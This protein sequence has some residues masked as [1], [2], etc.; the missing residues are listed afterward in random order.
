MQFANLKW[1]NQQPYS[2]DFDDVY[3]SSD[4]GLAETEYVFIQ[5]NQLSERFAALANTKQSK[6]TFTIIET[7]FGTGLN[8]LC[9]AQHFLDQAPADAK[10]Q[11]ISIEKYPLS[12]QDL[13]KTNKNWPMFNAQ[14][15]QLH[16]SYQQLKAGL[17]TFTLCESRITLSLWV[18]DV[19]QCLPQVHDAADA[20]FLDGF[21]PS[22][23]ADMWTEHLFNNIARLSKAESTFSTFTSASIVRRG[24]QSAGFK[25]IKVA[26]FGKKREMLA[27]TF[28]VEP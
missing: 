19:S 28:L 11:F 15:M 27:G 5:H 16:S 20:W 25:V 8:F 12:L 10:L 9:A 18:G 4:G 2:L 6:R 26:G 24:L 3:F 14:A 1:D 21:A 7:G 23:N 22:K 13:I 17:N